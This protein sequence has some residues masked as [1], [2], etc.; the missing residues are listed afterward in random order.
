MIGECR[1]NNMFK[2]KQVKIFAVLLLVLGG[3]FVITSL[4]RD[5]YALSSK[6]YT[7][8]E[9]QDMVVSTALNYF[10][11]T[12]YSDY[13]QTSMDLL[14]DSTNYYYYGTVYWRDL[15]MTPD[16]VNRGN[17]YRT[18]CSAFAFLAYMNTFGYDAS[19][20]S[21]INR[22]MLFYGQ[23]EYKMQRVNSFEDHLYYYRDAYEKFGQGWN[24]SHLTRMVRLCRSN[25][26]AG[27]TP[28]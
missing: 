10:Y 12:S 13:G 22:Y 21:D 8:E 4:M 9:M 25:K 23:N 28:V 26:L 17:Y 20:F 19:E 11:N 6:V 2:M 1:M 27:G 15:N 24:N 3:A 14:S 16:M 18:D 5:S 7:R